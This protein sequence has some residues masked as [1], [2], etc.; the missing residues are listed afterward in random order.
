MFDPEVA[1]GF[2][3]DPEERKR[4]L[5]ANA[6]LGVS[7]GLLGARRGQEL[8]GLGYGM[9]QGAG[10]G[11]QAVSA[12]SQDKY[13]QFRMMS[14]GQ[15]MVDQRKAQEQAA[16]DAQEVA[17]AF[18]TGAPDVSPLANGQ[19]PTVANAAAQLPA[20]P[21]GDQYRKA[22]QIYMR[23]NNPEKAKMAM[24]MA[25]K[26][27]EE[28][29]TTP[30]V[31]VGPDGP[32]NYVL[33]KRG[34]EKRLSAG[35]AP[36]F[37]EV[38]TGGK[39]QVVNEYN[40]PS[41]GQSF[42]VTMNPFQVGSL[43]VDQGR[44]GLSQQQFRYQQDRDAAAAANKPPADAKPEKPTDQQLATGSFL[45]RMQSATKV[46]DAVEK[47]YSPG[48]DQTAANVFRSLPV[49]GGAAGYAYDSARNAVS[50]APA[51]Y[52]NAQDA[53][54]RAKLRKESGAVIGA[55]EM[56][57]EKRT[58]FPQPN[59]PPEVRKQ[60]K[61]LREEVEK[62]MEVAARGGYQGAGSDPADPLGLR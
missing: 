23:Q 56:E 5:I 12:A 36:K 4:L 44:L 29:S 62:S 54:I 10:M 61:K 19:G 48:G 6:L 52:N 51:M 34:T 1:Q 38:N 11:Q 8:Q 3:V 25:A 43:A 15:K 28:F 2:S 57:A 27:D 9:L 14:E 41:T 58:F 30:N 31:G 22:A 55:E 53:W 60:K 39:V 20:S 37:R 45:A 18:T 32:Y 21:L 13:N 16:R 47:K 33:G 49:I 40:L 24:E 50:P 35:V 59:D 42:D 46:L 17:G 26:E 7:G